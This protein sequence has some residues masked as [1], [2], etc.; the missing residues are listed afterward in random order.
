MVKVSVQMSMVDMQ[1]RQGDMDKQSSTIDFPPAQAWSGTNAQ[2]GCHEC[3]C[4]A[5]FNPYAVPTEPASLPESLQ[6][7]QLLHLVVP[8]N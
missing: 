4:A 3:A 8:F 1:M 6:K 7:L 2:P 5:T